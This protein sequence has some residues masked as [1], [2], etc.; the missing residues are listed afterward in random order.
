VAIAKVAATA[1][2]DILSP[3]MIPPPFAT[4]PG[5]AGTTLPQGFRAPRVQ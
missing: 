5:S 1:T 3:V 4:A 2:I